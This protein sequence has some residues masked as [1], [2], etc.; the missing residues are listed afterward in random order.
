MHS[1]FLIGPMILRSDWKVERIFNHS[2]H[3]LHLALSP[4]CQDDLFRTPQVP[5]GYQNAP[6]KY[7]FFEKT[8]IISIDPIV[9]IKCMIAQIVEAPAYKLPRQETAHQGSDALFNLFLGSLWTSA[10]WL[11]QLAFQQIEPDG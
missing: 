3:A 6:A 7:L 10:R 1:D 8:I 9:Q 4:I 11:A 5:I 2:E